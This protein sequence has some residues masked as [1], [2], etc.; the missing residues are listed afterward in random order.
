[1][2]GSL[3]LQWKPDDRT[4]ISIDGLYARF[5]VHRLDNMIDARSMGRNASNNGQ[6]MMS[7]KDIQVDDLGSLIHGLWD[8]VDLRSEMQDDKFTSTFR[9]VNLNFDHR[10]TDSFRVYGIAGISDSRL[11]DNKL[12]VA[13]DANDT[14]NFSIDFRNNPDIPKLGYGV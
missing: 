10:F 7:I 9:Q 3:T 4:D 13:M 1:L 6:P 11:H 8:G 2:A 12:Q 14:D 5:K